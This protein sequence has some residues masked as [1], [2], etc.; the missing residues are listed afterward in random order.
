MAG[1]VTVDDRVL[2]R[3]LKA[4]GK[5]AEKVQKRARREA[6]NQVRTRAKREIAS[7][8]NLP[9]RNIADRMRVEADARRVYFRV[10][11]RPEPAH[12]F[13]GWKYRERRGDEVSTD[14]AGRRRTT[15]RRMRR[16]TSGLT[17]RF[18]KGLGA[19]RFSRA[20]RTAPVG[21]GR[22]FIQRKTKARYPTE[23]ITGPTAH[24]KTLESLSQYAAVGAAAYRR[25]LAFWTEREANKV[26]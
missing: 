26:R 17:V 19:L 22:V 25:R 21:Y 5:R 14:F 13:R 20:F 7:V 4:L 6:G 2:K 15:A 23:A 8:I 24:G 16:G 11:Y 18:T 10:R 3:R 12:H 1:A 9:V